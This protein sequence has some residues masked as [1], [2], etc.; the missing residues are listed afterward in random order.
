MTAQLTEWL[1]Q[2]RWTTLL[3]LALVAAIGVAA[4]HWTWVAFAPRTLAPPAQLA[5][6]VGA[7][8]VGPVVR[9]GLFGPENGAA[10][11][12]LPATGLKLV[13]VIAEDPAAPGDAARAILLLSNG[14]AKAAAPGEALAPGLVLRA[15]HADHVIVA[16]DGVLENIALEREVADLHAVRA[17]AAQ[18]P[19]RS[20]AK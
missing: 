20:G 16:R 19:K 15:V 10:A 18:S 11:H 9:R 2:G 12:A 3:D 17:G 6:A 4:A 14:E 7:G 13:G 5:P 8:A 1:R